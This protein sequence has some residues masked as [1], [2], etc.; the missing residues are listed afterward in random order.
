MPTLAVKF[1]VLAFISLVIY[2]FEKFDSNLDEDS[3]P[4]H[5]CVALS[6][7]S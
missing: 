3:S 1:K 4:K 2:L 6:L 7:H 5:V